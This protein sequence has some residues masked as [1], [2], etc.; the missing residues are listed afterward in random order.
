L[1]A[2]YE[3]TGD[4]MDDELLRRLP[5]LLKAWGVRSVTWTGGGEPTLHAGFASALLATGVSMDQ[6]LYTNGTL[7]DDGL[8]HIVKQACRWVYVSLDYADPDDYV[9]WKGVDAYGNAAAGIERLAR[10]RG[11]AT[12]GV[13]FLLAAHNWQDAKQMLETARALGADYAQFRPMVVTD[14]Q[15]PGRPAEDTSWIGYFLAS[16][17]AAELAEEADV[18]LD[19]RRFAMY[20]N[21][22]GHGYDACWWCSLQTVVTPDGRAWLCANRRGQPVACLGHVDG[23][24]TN[25]QDIRAPVPVEVGCRAM[26]R[27]HL[28]NLTLNEVMVEGPHASFI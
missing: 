24:A 16:A 6:G 11:D 7:L 3:A 19:L 10:A 23:V 8:A 5:T 28:P 4:L 17:M 21:W 15:V 1:P 27:G 2:D 9:T 14:P 18:Y 26:C 20:G 25:W 13:G 12:V 22:Q